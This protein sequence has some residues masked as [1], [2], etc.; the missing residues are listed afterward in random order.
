VANFT[1]PGTQQNTFIPSVCVINRIV[2]GA[3]NG[4]AV[5]SSYPIQLASGIGGSVPSVQADVDANINAG[6]GFNTDL[7]IG[8]AGNLNFNNGDYGVYGVGTM[9]LTWGG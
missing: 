3:T 4:W 2:F 7:T 8:G 5:N 6:I 1:V 9:A